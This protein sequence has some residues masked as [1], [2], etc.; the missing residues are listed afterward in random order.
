MPS[1]NACGNYI[2]WGG[3]KDA[4]MRFCNAKCH[5]RGFLS[6]VANELPAAEIAR[7]AGELQGG[8]CPVCRRPGPVDLQQAHYIWSAIYLTSWKSVP[9]LSCQRCGNWRRVRAM[10]SC[11]LLGWW[12]LPWGLLGTPIQIG[13]N[14][15]AMFRHRPSNE[16]SIEM[17]DLVRMNLAERVVAGEVDLPP[18]R[19]T[20]E[21][22]TPS[23]EI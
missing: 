23:G 9:S 20:D 7:L 11:G 1:C 15:L 17:L 13:R 10:L 16:P 19:G 5:R 6:V 2:M 12:G 18:A 8:P 21:E 14:V 22:E 3:V 4:G